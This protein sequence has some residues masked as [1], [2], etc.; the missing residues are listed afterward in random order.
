MKKLSFKLLGVVTIAAFGLGTASAQENKLPVS[1]TAGL[2]T[3]SLPINQTT[4]MALPLTDVIASGTITSVSGTTL[5]VSATLGTLTGPHAIKITSRDDQRGTGANA[6]AGSSTNAYGVSVEIASNT[7]STVTT[8]SAITPNVGDEFVIYPLETISSLFGAVPPAGWNG[9][10]GSASADVIFLDNGGALVGY[11]YKNSGLGGTG[12]RL[13]SA[14]GG[15]SQA[16]VVIPPNRGVFVQRR[17]A[18]STVN[19]TFTG[20]A[21]IGRETASV[22]TGFNVINNPFTVP[23][24]LA[25]STIQNH[26]TGSS[27]AASADTIFLENGGVL[28]AYFFKN[29]GLG[30]TGWR[31]TTAPGGADQGSVVLTPGKAILVKEQAGTVGFALPEP[32]AE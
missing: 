26:I 19:F 14:P 31:L 22:A 30:G 18:G 7:A 15:A 32:F 3:V 27:G 11:F 6:P 29:A 9:S 20:V 16:N 1:R 13:S 12:W 4:L 5:G 8:S 2:V 24:T 23:T 28:T 10:S 21:Q 17:N 25:A